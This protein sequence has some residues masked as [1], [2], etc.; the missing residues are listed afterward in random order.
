MTKKKKFTLAELRPIA[1]KVE[2]KH[3]LTAEGLGVFIEMVGTESA[4]FRNAF[5]VLA[6]K[7]ALLTA[8][9]SKDID[10]IES[11]S[12]EMLAV[13]VLGWSDDEF[14]GSAFSHEKLVEVLADPELEFIKTQLN[15]FVVDRTNFFRKDN[16]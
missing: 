4:E 15:E 2:L 6:K 9:E 7:R 10:L 12:N 8:D 11:D 16:K 5:K 13:C 14:F 3:P 1:A